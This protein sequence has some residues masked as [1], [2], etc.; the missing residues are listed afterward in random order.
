M[1]IY[2]V[3]LSQW[4]PAEPE[5]ERA[6]ASAEDHKNWHDTAR[7]AVEMAKCCVCGGACDWQHAWG[8][9]AIPWGYGCEDIWCSQDCLR[10]KK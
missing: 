8:M 3:H 6:W 5:G 9:H 7:A 10:A 2:P 1:S 4:F